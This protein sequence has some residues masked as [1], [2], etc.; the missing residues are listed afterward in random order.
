LLVESHGTDIKTI[1]QTKAMLILSRATMLV[2]R[3]R[4]TKK[5]PISYSVNEEE[6]GYPLPFLT[7]SSSEYS[8]DTDKKGLWTGLATNA[9]V[10]TGPWMPMIARPPL[11]SIIKRMMTTTIL[12]DRT[13]SSMGIAAEAGGESKDGIVDPAIQA[14]AWVRCSR[15]FKYKC[16]S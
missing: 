2:G 10:F 15:K 3:P 1:F 14:R 12:P 6:L 11:M 8:Y 9:I 5:N 16:I 13:V 4:F 7:A